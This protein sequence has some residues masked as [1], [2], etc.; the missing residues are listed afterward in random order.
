[1][2]AVAILNTPTLL[3]TIAFKPLTVFMPK[4]GASSANRLRYLSI[5]LIDTKD[6]NKV[7]I[8]LGR[9][10]TCVFPTR[11]ITVLVFFSIYSCRIHTNLIMTSDNYI[12][13]CYATNVR[14][15]ETLILR[16]NFT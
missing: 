1:M 4:H 8:D 12:K 7:V 6:R 10:G 2:L 5:R 16:A 11:T 9:N 15:F 13:M 3:G 14:K